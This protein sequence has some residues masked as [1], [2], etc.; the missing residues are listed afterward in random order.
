MAQLER[1]D[2][3]GE[4]LSLVGEEVTVG[5]DQS[6]DIVIAGDLRVSRRL[7]VLEGR[8]GQWVV[9][10]AGSRNGTFVNGSRISV[11]PLRGGDTVKVGSAVFVFS[12]DDDPYAT[13]TDT[14]ESSPAEPAHVLSPREREVVDLVGRGATDHDIATALFISVATV[15]SHL[16]RI[17]DKTGCRRRS[18]LT[19]LA[20]ELGLSGND[21]KH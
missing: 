2:H 8:D 13:L 7:A 4:R 10:D 1:S 3:P 11:H 14:E 19:R 6:N 18:E 15:R 16:D 5:R 9:R 20:I 12:A 17:R 21:T